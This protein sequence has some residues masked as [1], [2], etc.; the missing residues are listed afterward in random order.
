MTRTAIVS[1]IHGNLSALRSVLADIATVG[2]DRIV[3]LGDIVGYG[4][5]PRECLDQSMNFDFCILGNHDSSALF[6]PEGFNRAAESAIFWTR[7]QI[8]SGPDGAQA[9]RQRMQF[10]CDMPRVKIEGD[11]MFVHGSP[12]GP[13]NE[14]VFPEDTQ[15]VKKMEKL[16]S[17]VPRV[18]FQGHTH[19]PGIFTNGLRFLKPDEVG[20]D[21]FSIG[22][23]GLRTMVNVGSVGQPRDGDN[24]SCYVIL[25]DDR[26]R[27]RRVAYDIEETVRAVEAEPDLEN[28]LGYRLREGR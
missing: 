15:N 24:R 18:C 12:R 20:N 23:P 6:D 9:S 3:C 11:L 1:D 22:Q 25:Q 27:F 10:I 16:F 4:P 5:F 28:L 13:T 7:R 8:E 2:V 21:G 26:V 14:Y 19:M 17:L